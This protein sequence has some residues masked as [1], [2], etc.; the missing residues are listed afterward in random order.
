MRGIAGV[1][2]IKSVTGSDMVA[3][4]MICVGFTLSVRMLS[5]A[6]SKKFKKQEGNSVSYA[7]R[8]LMAGQPQGELDGSS[9]TSPTTQVPALVFVLTLVPCF[10]HKVQPHIPTEQYS[11]AMPRNWCL[12]V[13][14]RMGNPPIRKMGRSQR[15]SQT[16][17]SAISLQ[18]RLKEWDRV[19]YR[20]MSLTLPRKVRAP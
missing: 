6:I 11:Q 1:L 15:G 16:E 12:P 10:S 5:A 14:S 9:V 3:I 20:W 7:V 18:I 19:L 2:K 8:S 4:F 17:A 13:T